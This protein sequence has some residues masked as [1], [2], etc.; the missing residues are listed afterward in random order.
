MLADLWMRAS[1]L[2]QSEPLYWKQRVVCDA[3]EDD[4]HNSD[5]RHPFY[6]PFAADDITASHPFGLGIYVAKLGMC[7]RGS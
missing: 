4:S 6:D 7:E 5:G 2:L 1:T 3:P